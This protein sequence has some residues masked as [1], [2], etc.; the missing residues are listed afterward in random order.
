M[1]ECVRAIMNLIRNER[2]RY[3]KLYIVRQGDK[4]ELMF[5]QL[6]VEDRTTE[7]SVSYVDFLC[8]LHKE[9]RT[10]LS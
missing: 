10:L 7:G 4:M 3:M 1:S 2:Q 5:R 8:H 6:L 9:I